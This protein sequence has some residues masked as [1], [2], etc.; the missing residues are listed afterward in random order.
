MDDILSSFLEDNKEDKLSDNLSVKQTPA[1]VPIQ[2]RSLRLSGV[3]M[4]PIPVELETK[5]PALP[6]GAFVFPDT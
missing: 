2:S 6:S 1:R 3:K 4:L 5:S